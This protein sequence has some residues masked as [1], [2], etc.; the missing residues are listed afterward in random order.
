MSFYLKAKTFNETYIKQMLQSC[1]IYFIIVIAQKKKTNSVSFKNNINNKKNNSGLLLCLF[2]IFTSLGNILSLLLF[3][4][5]EKMTNYQ[6]SQ[7]LI[8]QNT[9]SK[10]T[11]TDL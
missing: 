6:P 4:I 10:Q 8:I 7:K 1:V 9:D 3:Q 5:D 11:N 2:N